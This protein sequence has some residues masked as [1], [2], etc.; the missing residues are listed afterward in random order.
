MG[1]RPK[2]E[3]HPPFSSEIPPTVTVIVPTLAADETLAECLASL[4]GQTFSD[5]E[6]IVVDNSGRCAVQP[7]GRIRVI[8]NKNNIGFGA[9]VNQ[10]FRESKSSF[11]A[12][13]NDDA[14]ADP[15][16]LEALLAAVEARPDVG[17]CASQVRLAGDGRLDSAGMLLCLDGSSKQRG[18]LESPESFSRRQEALL[19]S[20]SAA[21]YRREM[22]E[23]IG[24]FD[25][26]FFLYCEDTDLGLRARWAA[27]ECLYVPDAVVEHRYS[28][29][30]GSA[31]ALKAYYVERNRL[32][33]A[34]KNLPMPELLLAP[35][36]SA[37]RYF[38]HVVFA[39]QGRGKTADF[40]R[41]GNSAKHLPLYVLRAHLALFRHFP[42]LWKQRRKIKR[43]FTPKQFRRLIRRFSITPRQVA[44]L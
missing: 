30:A 25:E 18:H 8:A 34:V 4:D 15:R 33:L 9:A 24:L 3:M 35:F 32:F 17:M 26:A 36:Y 20:G 6:V 12:V 42:T 19:P 28:H 2:P 40:R 7:Q 41:S 5:F 13:L 43:R 29:S 10:A 37:A 22:L 31:S 1:P 27:W 14:M 21:F 44:A 16:W 39:I 23:E 38:W 11:L